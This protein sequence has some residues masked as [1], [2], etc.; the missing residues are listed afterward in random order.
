ML[1]MRVL[2]V[3]VG[4]RAGWRWVARKMARDVH[5]IFIKRHNWIFERAQRHSLLCIN[6]KMEGI[7]GENGALL[8]ILRFMHYTLL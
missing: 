1:K 2:R 8:L 6:M 4:W 3:S 5:W 7:E